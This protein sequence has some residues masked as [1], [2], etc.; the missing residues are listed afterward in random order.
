MIWWIN[1]YWLIVSYI[2]LVPSYK[3]FSLCVYIIYF[4]EYIFNIIHG[5]EIYGEE[6]YLI[7]FA[8]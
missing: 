8:E 6:I 2:L 7:I 5:V 4:P 3:L 1:V